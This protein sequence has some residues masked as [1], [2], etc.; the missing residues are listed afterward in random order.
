MLNT[1]S[2][3]PHQIAKL[4]NATGVASLELKNGCIG[5]TRN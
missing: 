1:S 3:N 4:V 2:A 5:G